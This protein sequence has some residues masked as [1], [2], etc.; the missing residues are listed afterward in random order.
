[1]HRRLYAAHE[2]RTQRIMTALAAALLLFAGLLMAFATATRAQTVKI[3][4]IGDYGEAGQTESDVANLVKSWNPDY[5]ITNGDNN[6]PFGAAGTIDA[7]IGRYYHAYIYPYTGSY[8][9]GATVNRF[10][11]SI[12]NH[13]YGDKYPNAAAI[14][15]YL[16]YF[17]LPNNERYYDFVAGPVH[18]FSLDSD[19]NEADGTSSNSAQ[20]TWLKNKLAAAK[21]RWKI[22]YFHHPPYASSQYY[23]TSYMRWPFQAWGAT[24]V[25]CGHLHAYE[26]IMKS[27]FPYLTNGLGGEPEISSFDTIEP[28]SVVRYNNDF[29]AMRITASPTSI[30]FDFITRFGLLID[31]F[32]INNGA[33]AGLAATAGDK[34]AALSWT[35][36]PGATSYNIKRA[37]TFGGPYTKIASSTGTS[38]TNTGLTNGTTYYYVVAANLSAGESANS[39]EASATPQAAALRINAGGNAYSGVIGTFVADTDYSGGYLWSYS[40]R[41]IANTS[42]PALYLTV[43]ASDTSF[44]YSLAAA[45]GPYTLKLHFAECTQTAAG[46]RL[47][48]ITVNGMRVRTNYDIF[49]T[50]GGMNIAVIESIP[51]TA[52]NGK[53]DLTIASALTTTGAVLAAL[54]LIPNTNQSSPPTAPTGLTGTPA[55]QAATLSWQPSAL[56]TS[57]SVKR[58]GLSGGQYTTVAS[59]LTSTN[60]TDGGLTGGATYYYVVTA[61]NS[62]GESGNSNE[63]A[64]TAQGQALAAPTNLTAVAGNKQAS[65]TWAASAGATGYTLLRATTS[66]GPYS[67]VA[68]NITATLY[69]NTGL[70]NGT[71]YYYVVAATNGSSQSTNSNE[72]SVVPN[73]VTLRINCGGSAYTGTI[74]SFIADAYVTGGFPWSYSSRNI[75]GTS[76]PALYLDVRASD[77]NFTYSLPVPSGSYTLK[78]HFAECTYTAAGQRLMNV[79]VNGVRALTNFD[80]IATAGAMNKAVI[81]SLPA[82]AANG[83]I[84]LTVTSALTSSGAALAAIEVIP[85]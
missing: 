70:T 21:E 53:V 58:S 18:F 65:L 26:R 38:Y 6:Y 19:A 29:G 61:S 78:L 4:D 13:D 12:G 56:A 30:T 11:P 17:T 33:P 84:D 80:I 54:E 66:G 81:Q 10:F 24:A 42:D 79:D 25:V 43:R 69:I 62:A 40:N 85:N 36:T 8:G 39:N 49:A 59:G 22:V 64:V 67:T 50:A 27:G 72:A 41:T 75:V 48:N 5:I 7:N 55:P 34:Q 57:Y 32:T 46:V 77:T 15:P 68:T 2:G 14:A 9:A 73:G 45:T 52:V 31:S 44:S 1:M 60:Y 83:N 76:D 71:T 3:A 51:V 28:G 16:N 37:T 20:A 63:A 35:A 74:G 47:L 23:I 82:T